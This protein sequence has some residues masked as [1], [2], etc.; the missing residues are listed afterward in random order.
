MPDCV[1]LERL[2]SVMCFAFPAGGT[3]FDDGADDQD[4]CS[5]SD[6]ICGSTRGVGDAAASVAAIWLVPI[7][8]A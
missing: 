8:A 5:A 3:A 7:I 4:V 2:K 6:T 1:S